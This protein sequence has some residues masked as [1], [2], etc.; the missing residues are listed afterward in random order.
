MKIIV[1]GIVAAVMLAGCS[2]D[3]ELAPTPRSTVSFEARPLSLQTPTVT[4]TP[5]P[6][7]TEETV[8]NALTKWLAGHEASWSSTLSGW[9]RV[10]QDGW[11]LYYFST[12]EAW[13][14]NFTFYYE[15]GPRMARPVKPGDDRGVAT[16]RW[17]VDD[18]TLSVFLRSDP[19]GFYK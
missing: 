12:D 3:G 9:L 4:P 7:Q 11:I 6:K 1:V 16:I 17:L 15:L 8:K 14:V 19:A 2:T 13:L 18:K 10:Q 5:A